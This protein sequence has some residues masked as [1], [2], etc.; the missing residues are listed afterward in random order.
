M[1]RVST[2]FSIICITSI[3]IIRLLQFCEHHNESVVDYEAVRQQLK[4]D[5]MMVDREFSFHSTDDLYF[6]N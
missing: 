4:H 5:Q 1:Q 2:I 6:E 3:I